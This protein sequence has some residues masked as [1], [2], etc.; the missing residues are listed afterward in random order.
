MDKLDVKNNHWN[1]PIDLSA[2]PWNYGAQIEI[3]FLNKKLIYL[4][5]QTKI[6][7]IIINV[8]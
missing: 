4:L 1:E 2:I 8:E 7:T 6:I 3:V 5:V